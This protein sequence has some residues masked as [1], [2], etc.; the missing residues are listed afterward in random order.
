MKNIV[1]FIGML[2]WI[3]FPATGVCSSPKSE[4][5]KRDN[6]LISKENKAEKRNNYIKSL[7]AN[8]TDMRFFESGYDAPPRDRRQYE[9]RF[10][11]ST[12]RYINWE[13]NLAHPKPQH[14]IDFDID[15]IWYDA[16]GKEFARQTKP[17]YVEA[18]WKMKKYTYMQLSTLT[19]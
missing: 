10:P 2:F 18:E 17:S 15:A 7:H 11:W 19:C 6:Y 4:G 14:R 16:D 3:I 5:A 8:I 1:I 13:L 12:S 9:M